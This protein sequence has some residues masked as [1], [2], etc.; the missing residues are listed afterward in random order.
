MN[1]VVPPPN[2]LAHA[3]LPIFTTESSM[4]VSAS[5][6]RARF[7]TLH[8]PSS[9]LRSAGSGAVRSNFSRNALI[10][11]LCFICAAVWLA[12]FCLCCCAAARSLASSR[13]A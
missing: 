13:L 1:S 5:V 6:L 8:L 3:V 7:S 9:G 12:A 10:S 11:P 4:S 2:R